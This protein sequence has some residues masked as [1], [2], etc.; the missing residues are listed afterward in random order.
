MRA[1]PGATGNVSPY[2]SFRGG[3][4]IVDED[5][6]S[7]LENLPVDGDREMTPGSSGKRTP[8]SIVYG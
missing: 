6:G 5:W 8:R 7:R 3:H 1:P 2:L 4:V